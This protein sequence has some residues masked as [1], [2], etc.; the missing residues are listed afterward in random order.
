MAPSLPRVEQA[1][2][3]ER[4]ADV[5]RASAEIARRTPVLSSASLSERCGARS[6]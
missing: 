4:L 2:T 3:L 6:R 1:L 5:H